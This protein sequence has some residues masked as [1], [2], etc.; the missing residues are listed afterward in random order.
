MSS[1]I[2]NYY[3]KKFGSFQP[4]SAIE[5]NELIVYVPDLLRMPFIY[6]PKK[7]YQPANAELLITE[8]DLKTMLYKTIHE[9]AN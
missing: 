9:T 5:F 8:N 2:N 1:K 3:R 7:G 6:F 4:L